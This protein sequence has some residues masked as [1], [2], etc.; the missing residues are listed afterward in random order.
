M[1]SESSESLGNHTIQM[2]TLMDI[3]VDTG[4]TTTLSISVLQSIDVSGMKPKYLFSSRQEMLLLKSNWSY[5][6]LVTEEL[7]GFICRNSLRTDTYANGVSP[8]WS[9][10]QWV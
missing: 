3:Y 5:L 7:P 4:K 9:R 2:V 8:Y 1:D 6:L 10:T